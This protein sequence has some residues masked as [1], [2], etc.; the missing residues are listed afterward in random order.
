MLDT[1]A[2]PW[3]GSWRGPKRRGRDTVGV[4]GVGNEEGVAFLDDSEYG[5]AVSSFNGS[6]ATPRSKKGL[7]LVLAKANVPNFHL[8]TDRRLRI[9]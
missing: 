3:S 9:K 8:T 2:Q 4:D 1:E 7:S 5:S 6:G